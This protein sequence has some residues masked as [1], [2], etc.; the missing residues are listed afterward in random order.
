VTSTARLEL[1]EALAATDVNMMIILKVGDSEAYKGVVGSGNRVIGINCNGETDTAE[2]DMIT[3][4]QGEFLLANSTQSALT[5][6]HIG[7]V[8]HLED[9]Y[10]VA[11]AA[12]NSVVAGT[13]KEVVA[14]G[15]WV[16]VGVGEGVAA[17][18]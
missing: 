15:V 5:A 16:H 14:E 17:G 11:L 3:V 9:A 7:T 10:T 12:T 4:S 1:G 6:A 13:V 18:A 2:G 8:C